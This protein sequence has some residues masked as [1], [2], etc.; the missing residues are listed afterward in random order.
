MLWVRSYFA[1]SSWQYRQDNQHIYYAVVNWGTVGLGSLVE[2]EIATPRGGA[3]STVRGTITHSN[4]FNVPT[5]AKP[6]AGRGQGAH[7][8]CFEAESKEIDPGMGFALRTSTLVF[9]C[10]A[11]MLVAA[12]GP[13]VGWVWWRRRRRAVRAMRG[14]CRRCGY[15]LRASV[16][17]CPECGEAV[18]AE[19]A[20]VGG[21]TEG[22]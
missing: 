17:R 19:K 8:Y 21:S 5:E 15:D 16:G 10:W 3:A 9:P 4:Y 22:A 11:V 7:L 13:A 20:A 2:R 6:I 12:V 18:G 1:V 14:L